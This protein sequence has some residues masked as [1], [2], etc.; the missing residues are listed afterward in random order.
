ME[1]HFTELLVRWSSEQANVVFDDLL[2]AL[3]DKFWGN[4]QFAALTALCKVGEE[5]GK[6]GH[7]E[8]VGTVR[9]K[10][11]PLFHK[12]LDIAMSERQLAGLGRCGELLD[13][14]CRE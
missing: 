4:E 6:M 13:K 10:L 8:E 11:A 1:E 7:F 9:V 12:G 14:Y 3:F 5:L 2:V